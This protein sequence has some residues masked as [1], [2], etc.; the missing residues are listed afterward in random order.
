MFERL[1][2]GLKKIGKTFLKRIRKCGRKPKTSAKN[3]KMLHGLN[4]ADSKKISKD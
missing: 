4:I 1:V 2:G 3:D